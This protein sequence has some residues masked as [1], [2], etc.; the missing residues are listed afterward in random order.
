M[1]QIQTTRPVWAKMLR[2][3]YWIFLPLSIF[4][5]FVIGLAAFA[6]I[7]PET[8]WGKTTGYAITAG[9]PLFTIIALSVSLKEITGMR[10]FFFLFPFVALLVFLACIFILQPTIIAG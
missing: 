4:G 6:M 7:D 10:K 5:F 8:I 2:V 3:F 1:D 9:F